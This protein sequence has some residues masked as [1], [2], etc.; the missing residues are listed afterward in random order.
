MKRL[1][2]IF[3]VISLAG[4]Q[5]IEAIPTLFL[6]STPTS[7]LTVTPTLTPLP[8]PKACPS[9]SA[10]LTY[11][12]PDDPSNVIAMQSISDFLN[13]GGDPIKLKPY[14]ETV[15]DDMNNDSI[16]EV[17][18]FQL[19]MIYESVYLFACINGKYE[20]RFGHYDTVATE[21]IE[22]MTV[23]D[24]N[25]NGVPEIV[26]KEIGCFGLRCGAVFIVEWDGKKFTHLV[27]G[28]YFT[29]R[30]LDY[31]DLADPYEIYLKDIDNDGIPELVW[32]GGLPSAYHGEHWSYYPSRIETHVYRW[33]GTSYSALPIIYDAPEFRFQAVQDGD[34]YTKR[35]EY[36]KAL[37]S[38]QLAIESNDLEWWTESRWINIMDQKGIKTCIERGTPCPPLLP[39]SK[40]RPT[41]SAYSIYRIT[42]VHLLMSNPDEAEKTYN[43]LLETYSSNSS[44][45]P[46]VQMATLFWNEFQVSHNIGEACTKVVAYAADYPNILKIVSGS[47]HS[48]QSIDYE[49]KPEEF[50]PF[51]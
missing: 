30:P 9:I 48:F 15:I 37:T 2:Y 41:L 33:D 25:R 12:L 4:C 7:S 42:L 36:N 34:R 5:T 29:D 43:N 46:V 23:S 18:A 6:T 3:L 28:D 11:K 21:Q 32:I 10:D 27:K 51:K 14:F 17:L 13:M 45:Y 22:I 50:C 8:T 26:V 16:P 38:Y 19:D 1:L 44:V 40:E 49:Y 24:L 20:E 31:A 39:D 47:Q 35:G